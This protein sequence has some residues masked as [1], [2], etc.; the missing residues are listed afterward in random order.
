MGVHTQKD[1]HR[2]GCRAHEV[3]PLANPAF[4]AGLGG[5][6]A[7]PSPVQSELCAAVALGRVWRICP[8][9]KH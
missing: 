2:E 8:L 9:S 7:C 5:G 4:L 6:R 1:R 3:M